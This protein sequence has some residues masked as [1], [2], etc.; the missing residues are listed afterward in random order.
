MESGEGNNTNFKVS[1]KRIA[2]YGEALEEE[3]DPIKITC[4]TAEDHINEDEE[5]VN[6]HS[7]AERMDDKVKTLNGESILNTEPIY[8]KHAAIVIS[9]SSRPKRAFDFIMNCLVIYSVV[10]SLYYLGYSEPTIG[11]SNF[12][13]AVWVLFIID[14]ILNFFTEITGTRK[15]SVKNLKMISMSYAMGWMIFDILSLIPLHFTSIPRIEYFLRLFRV[16]KMQRL[17][18]MFHVDQINNFLANR[19]YNENQLQTKKFMIVLSYSWDLFYQIMIMLFVSYALSCI[20]SYTVRAIIYFHSDIKNFTDHFGLADNTNIEKMI[21]TWYF[22]YTTL[23]T[24]GYG[25]YY[26]TNMY[27][28]GLCI[29]LLILGPAWYAYAMSSAITALKQLEDIKGNTDIISDVDTWLSTLDIHYRELPVDLKDSIISHFLYYFKNDRAGALAEKHWTYESKNEINVIH[30]KFLNILPEK[31]RYEILDFLFGDIFIK[32]RIF[33]CDEVHFKY[34]ICLHIQP[35]SYPS[36]I[37]IIQERSIPSEILFVEHGKVVCGTNAN[38]H[39][40][41]FYT[42]KNASIL[43][44]YFVLNKLPSFAQFISRRHVTGFA[45]PGK[46]ARQIFKLYPVHNKNYKKFSR[47]CSQIIENTLKVEK[48]KNGINEEVRSEDPTP[49]KKSLK[50]IT[51]MNLKR[52]GLNKRGNT[53]IQKEEAVYIQ[54]AVKTLNNIKR[55]QLNLVMMLKDKFTEFSQLLPNIVVKN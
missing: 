2:F 38:S 49:K 15:K 51:K 43:G 35:R 31:Q 32:F 54:E 52:S 26:A 13:L 10:S 33:F 41:Q 53:L 28:M 24:V 27:E 16:F 12:D 7:D 29:L 14:F 4:Y 55:K 37:I 19:Y 18:E 40:F 20:W 17:F 11:E 8:Q 48:K 6:H 22:I 25:D 1:S 45:I 44:D 50:P 5:L 36:D 42:F 23:M 30:N 46:V 9:M 34:Q 3:K 39:F 47:K 21:K